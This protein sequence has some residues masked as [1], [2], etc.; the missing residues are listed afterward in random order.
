[1]KIATL[2]FTYHRDFHTEQV[3]KALKENTILPQILLIFQD[4]LREDEDDS[5]WRRV[6]KLIQ[7]IDWC[8]KEIIVS[9]YNKGLAESIV[10]GI[11]Y[12]FQK[13]DA[14]IVLEDD[15]VALPSYMQFMTQ[16]LAKYERIK[17]VYSVSGFSWPGVMKKSRFDAY[18]CG[19]VSSLGWGTWKDR[20]VNFK[21]DINILKRIKADQIKSR[22]L[23]TWGKDLEEMLTGT[24]TGQYDSWG[25]YWALN[26]I[27]NDGICI[28]PY[29][30]LIKHIGWDDT[31]TNTTSADAFDIVILNDRV[32]EFAFP[33][34]ITILDSTKEAFAELYGSYTAVSQEKPSKDNVLI[35]GLGNFFKQNEKNVNHNFNIVAFIDQRKKGWYAGKKILKQ[36]DVKNYNFNKILIMVLDIQ[37]CIHI[38]EELVKHGIYAEQIVLGSSLYGSWNTRMD[39]IT[40]LHEENQIKLMLSVNGVTIKI[41]SKDEFYNAYDALVNQIWNYS[42]NNGREDVVLDVGMNI[43][44]TILYFLNKKNVRKVYGYEPFQETYADAVENLQDYL[45][46]AER[47]KV[48]PYGISSENAERVIGFNRDMTCGQSTILSIREEAYA[49]YHGEGLVKIENEEQEK[50]QV[51]DAAEVFRPIMEEYGDCNMVLKM[52]C[53]GEEYA[54]LERLASEQLLGQFSMIMLEWHYKGK[55]NI[56]KYLD[57]AG[58]TYW[59][60]DKERNMGLIYAC[61][62]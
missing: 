11:D 55:D 59:C 56:L 2:L 3:L 7:G 29:V 37:E 4:G 57:A 21:R 62:G 47:V 18:S 60:Q 48:F 35:Y 9:D 44:D 8:D 12:A 24:I 16:G 27:E 20:W 23:F 22:N 25:V 43:G 51:R 50:I 45:Q 54:I 53:E 19:R 6:N 31:G 5:E 17:N 49:W 15:C 14:V 13:Y 46:C 61:R 41:R 26:V 34:D 38:A 28:N 1:M 39:R 10:S 58:F 32:N 33:D 42:I 52:N 36:K 40:V 30:S